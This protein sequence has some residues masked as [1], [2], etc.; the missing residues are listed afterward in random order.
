MRMTTLADV[1]SSPTRRK[2]GMA[3]RAS[4]SMPLKSCAIIDCRVMGVKAVPTRTPAMR[5]KATGTPR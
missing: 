1:I 3:I 5:A 2:N 4:E